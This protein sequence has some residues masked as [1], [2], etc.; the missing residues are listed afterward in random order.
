LQIVSAAF[1]DFEKFGDRIVEE[2]DELGRQAEKKPPS[3]VH[4]NAYGR[5]VDELITD[6]SWSKLHDI[7]AEEGLIS[8]AYCGPYGEWKYVVIMC[9]YSIFTICDGIE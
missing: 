3:L 5:R 9:T 2:V 8:S 1:E 7:S 4:Y 6:H